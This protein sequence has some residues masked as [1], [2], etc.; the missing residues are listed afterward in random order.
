[1]KNRNTYIVLFILLVLSAG[2]NFIFFN[3]AK[4]HYDIAHS[5]KDIQE[6]FRDLQEKIVHIISDEEMVSKLVTDAYTFE[7][8]KKIAD[9]PFGVV[10]Y[11]NDSAVMWTNNMIIPVQAQTSQ[12]DIPLLI[13]EANGSYIV[14]KHDFP[15]SQIS[16]VG[17]LPLRFEYGIN[18]AYLTDIKT[19]GIYIPPY[20]SISPKASPDAYAIHDNEGEEIFYISYNT[21]SSFTPLFSNWFYVFIIITFLILLIIFYLFS[22]E[23]VK[24]FGKM[25]GIFV[26]L[27]SL[28]VLLFVL[29]IVLQ[30]PAFRYISLFDPAYYASTGIANSIGDL[31]IKTITAFT[32]SL[33][34]LKYFHGFRRNNGTGFYS[35]L[36]IV[37]F[38]FFGWLVLRIFKSLVFDSAISFDIHNFFSLNFF[39]LAGMLCITTGL[40][41]YLLISIRLL[42]FVF[43]NHTLSAAILFF[44]AGGVLLFVFIRITNIEAEYDPVLFCISII[45][46]RLFLQ[47]SKFRLR[48]FPAVMIWLIFF[49]GF[50]A[51]IVNTTLFTKSEENKK[52]FAIK[53]SVE[54]DALTEYLFSDIE[55]EITRSLLLQLAAYDTGQVKQSIVNQVRQDLQ[56]NYFK[57]Y[58]SDIFIYDN[59]SLLVSSNR[60]KDKIYKRNYFISAIEYNGETTAAQNLYFI[61]DNTGNYYYLAELPLR[62]DSI[63]AQTAYIELIPKRF[64]NKS[65]YPE[66]LIDDDL[67]TLQSFSGFDYAIYNDHSLID[68]EGEFS[69]PIMDVFYVEK[70]EEYA[71][72]DL[73]GYD[74]LI[75]RVNENKKV[76][77]SGPI[78]SFL[79]PF[80]Y[81]S[82]IFFFFLLFLSLVISVNF[83]VS[84]YKGKIKF[85]EWLNT[86]LQNKIQ[87]S[88]ISL[89]VFAFIMMGVAT[90][91]YI[92][93]QYNASHKQRLLTKI[94]AVQTNIDYI[95]DDSRKKGND[96]LQ[97]IVM[98]RRITNR[99][100]E[101]SEIHDMDIN[102]YAA[103]GELITSSQPDIFSRG[104]VSTKMNPLAYFKMSCD[105]ETWY[106]QDET[107]GKLKYLSAYV[108]IMDKVGEVIFYLNLPYFA[109]EQNLRAEISN[110]MVALINVYVLLL[111]IAAIIAFV[112]AQ[113]IT[114]PL[115]TIAGTFKNIKLGKKNEFISWKHEDEIGLLV[116]EYNAMLKELEKSAMLLA[117]SERESAWRDMAKQVAHE[118]K[119]PLTPMRLSIQHLQRALQSNA[120]NSKE[121]TE[122]VTKTLLEQIDNLSFIASE[123]SN[124]A[125]MPKANNESLNLND[126]LDNV[127][128]LFSEN[129]EAEIKM[130]LPNKNIFVYAD[131]N[132]LIRVFN[133]LIKNATQAITKD[134]EGC[135]EV[136]LESYDHRAVVK[137]KDNGIGI[138]DEQKEKVFVP[139][140]T[141]KSSG[142]GIGLAM[143]KN[144]IESA[145]GYIWFESE[146]DN[147]TT[148]FVEFPVV[149]GD[150]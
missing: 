15:N 138:T 125:I 6:E 143:S 124:F 121:L 8:F 66:L 137:V 114:K 148:F 89:I 16:T 60:D 39:S 95:F 115:A 132:Q 9:L 84:I 64:S 99:A 79:E 77:V 90:I 25:E 68:R 28:I 128:H 29:H 113:S 100:T 70:N 144:I 65:I 56:N 26:L 11:E 2:A 86:S 80:S 111:V 69:Y 18:N 87:V 122:K 55:N 130:I 10:V 24:R 108:P 42:D 131:K 83:I 102:L 54:K 146:P 44:A 75:Y 116:D 104:L 101:L 40:L 33:F 23:I 112:V 19:K 4:V 38:Y 106:I 27:C 88:V 123:F 147:G 91:V 34:F 17:F 133:N 52:L 98:L 1:M 71:D 22:E 57:K 150:E 63:H 53:K 3:D 59:D 31:L 92:T 21:A 5:A 20:F 103:S 93:N 127:V 118:I 12:N 51:Y 14:L 107:I 76:V 94:E 72:I 109:T 141:T 30:Q 49:A 35:F 62:K 82:Y 78:K 41:F 139:N 32:F 142:M 73:N 74:H 47:K 110:F 50:S 149:N 81:F 117:K 13:T 136:S 96:K 134:Q 140:F 129:E 120:P 85:K 105:K 7:E 36:S 67:K 46:I 45:L 61:N 145:G 135:I 126:V 43:R 58:E 97:S 119:N 48:S 37:V